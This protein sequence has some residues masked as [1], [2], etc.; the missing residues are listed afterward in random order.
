[1]LQVYMD[2]SGS[3]ANS[4][5]CVVAGYW[6]KVTEWRKV[7][8]QWSAVLLEFGVE[9]F[10]ANEFWPRLSGGRRNPPYNGWSDEKA[11]RFM[12][13]LLCVIETNRIFPFAFGVIGE[14]WEKLAERHRWAMTLGVVAQKVR[15]PMFVSLTLALVRTLDYCRTGSTINYVFDDDPKN[16]AL[17]EAAVNCF[18]QVRANLIADND[19]ASEKL[20]E[21]S[22]SD[23]KKAAPLQVADLL[24][25]EAHRYAKGAKGYLEF[26]ARESYKRALCR[27]RSVE[28]FKLVDAKRIAPLKERFKKIDNDFNIADD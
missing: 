6:A 9:E 15:K 18:S 4:H 20:G 26:P 23:S 2:D 22:F 14:E 3:H 25:Y 12:N 19:P 28:D 7:E 27:I 24:A 13:R 1:M 21:F 17:K 10:K 16:L 11:E 5:N 8:R